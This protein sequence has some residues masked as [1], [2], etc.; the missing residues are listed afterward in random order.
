MMQPIN[1]VLEAM[2]NKKQVERLT[3]LVTL[4]TLVVGMVPAQVVNA[5]TNEVVAS[6]LPAAPSGMSYMKQVFP[7]SEDRAPLRSKNVIA[8]AYS[9]DPYQ[10]DSTP[11]IPAVNYDLCEHAEQGEVNTIAAN[12]LAKGTKVRFP[13][14][15]GNKV[16]VVR[17]RMNKRYNGTNRIDMYIAVLDENGKLDN[18]ASKQTAK[19]FGLKRLKME[20]Y[21]K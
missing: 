21:G 13:E 12:F 14:L 3:A 17:D 18:Y 8:T 10:T 16:F 19:Q 7:V 15:Y 4:F 2:V 1:T 20:I 5:A 11:C 6:V 9:S